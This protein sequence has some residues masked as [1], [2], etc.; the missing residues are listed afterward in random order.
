MLLL[1]N[2]WIGAIGKS[3]FALALD[4]VVIQAPAPEAMAALT[5]TDP[6]VADNT[7]LA[8]ALDGL[9]GSV[10]SDG[11]QIVQAVVISPAFGLAD[12]DPAAVIGATSIDEAKT[13]LEAA[14]F[15]GT[16]GIPPYLGGIVADVQHELGPTV[17]IALTYPDCETADKSVA[18][19][20]ERWA[21]NMATVA[22]ANGLSIAAEGALCAAV[23]SFIGEDAG[24]AGN[25]LFVE[26]LS[27]HTRREFNLLQIG[28]AS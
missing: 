18:A 12:I 23:V 6:S 13:V 26:T 21:A 20:E 19:L 7:I 10:K 11:H 14:M 5:K 3:S 9:S 24:D 27:R 8:A 28:A 4:D 2:P 1:G 22:Q 15:E 25:P 17:T 16:Q